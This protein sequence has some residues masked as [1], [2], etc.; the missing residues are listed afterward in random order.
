[1]APKPTSA[2]THVKEP[3]ETTWASGSS[4]R[5]FARV[6]SRPNSGRKTK[7]CTYVTMAVSSESNASR[8]SLILRPSS[9]RFN[10]ELMSR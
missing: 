10:A 4:A 2:E 1:M 6:T 5:A 7:N 3:P 8:A 9:R